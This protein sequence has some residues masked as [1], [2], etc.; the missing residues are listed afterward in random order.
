MLWLP[1][2]EASLK[3]L[4]TDSSATAMNNPT[5]TAWVGYTGWNI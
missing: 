5:Y 4:I 2:A 3:D 1:T